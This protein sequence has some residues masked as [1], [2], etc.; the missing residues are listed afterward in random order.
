LTLFFA[1]LES[2]YV[3]AAQK[4]MVKLTPGVNF[5]NILL[6]AFTLADPKSAKKHSQIISLFLCFWGC[7]KAAHKHV[8]EIDPWIVVA[9]TTLVY[10]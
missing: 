7:V 2:G 8:G 3:K 10:H 5:I 4:I 1:L 9:M 6:K